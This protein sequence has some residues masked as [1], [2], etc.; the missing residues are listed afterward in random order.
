MNKL[1]Q[2]TTPAFWVLVVAI[3]ALAQLP[4]YQHVYQ[5]HKPW[6]DIVVVV[7]AAATLNRKQRGA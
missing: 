7:L 4:S 2:L 3:F 5:T 6:S 1:L